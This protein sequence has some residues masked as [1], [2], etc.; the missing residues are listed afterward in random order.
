MVNTWL[1]LKAVRS[2]MHRVLV[3]STALGLIGVVETFGLPWIAREW[4]HH[5][6]A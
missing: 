3:L 5:P 6:V 4:M 2:E 1:D